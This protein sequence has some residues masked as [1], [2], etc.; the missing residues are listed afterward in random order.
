VVAGVVERLDTASQT[1]ALGNL[2]VAY[3]PAGFA[4]GIDAGSL[5]NGSIVR[6]RANSQAA[7]GLL[8]ATLVENWYP[9]PKADGTPLQLEGV[10]AGYNGLAS[11]QLLGRTIDASA[12]K[13]TGGQP[14]KIGNG[15]TVG[16]SGA[17]SHGVLV[18]TKVRIIH[19]PGAGA[20]PSFTLIGNIGGYA[21]P[22]SFQVH[23]QKVDASGPG[24]VFV[25]GTQANLANGRAVTV[26]GEKIV[27]DALVASQVTF[28]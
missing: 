7:A 24:V 11:F 15:V 1:F 28:N 16:V 13:V 20:L 25:N 10:V 18:A 12:A 8:V 14:A 4:G 9:T 2:T 22:A 27:N 5:A 21:S 19:V 23:G 17:L 26:I 6:V 3:G